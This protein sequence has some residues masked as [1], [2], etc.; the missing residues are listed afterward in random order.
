MKRTFLRNILIQL[1]SWSSYVITGQP[2]ELLP[3]WREM[4]V[5]EC[6]V[7]L[8]VNASYIRFNLSPHNA[9][10]KIRCCY[11]WNAAL[12]DTGVTSLNSYRK[13]IYS[14]SW[15]R[16]FLTQP[17]SVCIRS[18][19]NYLPSCLYSVHLVSGRMRLIMN[20]SDI[21]HTELWRGPASYC[22]C[23]ETAH[24]T[25]YYIQL[26]YLKYSILSIQ[27]SIMNVK[28]VMIC[29][30]HSTV[31]LCNA[32]GGEYCAGVQHERIIEG[33]GG[34]DWGMGGSSR[35]KSPTWRERVDSLPLLLFL[36]HVFRLGCLG[37]T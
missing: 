11:L 37:F 35:A 34:S 2:V 5:E 13:E 26:N 18:R 21:S 3:R 4:S 28:S 27:L 31:M 6:T 15:V 32:F 17:R 19:H 30:F 20:A 25:E 22:T 36:D 33:G 29:S 14:S 7:W 10:A 16:R 1:L 24:G 23:L 8:V 9:E 12:S